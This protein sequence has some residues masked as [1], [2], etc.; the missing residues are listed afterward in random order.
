[1]V[2]TSKHHEGFCLWDS[3][4]T[5]Y[6]ITKTPFGRDLIKEY[7]AA[8]KAE[9][10]KV[11]YYYSVMD[12]H[13][14]DYTIDRPHPLFGRLHGKNLPKEEF[15]KKLAEMN[16]KRDMAKYRKYMFDQV[17]EL[18]TWYGKIDIIWFD[19]TPKGEYGKTW[20]D[21]D[22]VEL[23]KLARRLQPGILIDNRLDLLDTE[24]S[25]DF[26]TP[27]QYKVSETPK[28]NSVE[29]PWET[30]QTFSGSWGYYR[31]ESTWK[32][33]E[34]LIELLIHSVSFGGNLIMNVGPTARGEF[35]A[36]ACS[37]LEAFGKWMHSNSRSIYGCTAAPK[38]F[39]APA[40]TLL[41]YNP[42][43]KRLYVHLLAYPMGV[44][45]VDFAD[46][47]AYAQ[48]LHDGSELFV[49]EARKGH[50]QDGGARPG[51]IKLPMAK[52][53]VTIPVI[54]IFLKD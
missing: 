12:W 13:H 22:A 1:M 27:E 3:K 23:V 8:A 39:K 51:G 9:G 10:L 14:P 11:G 52:P 38:E 43:K 20:R 25:W 18:L 30:C 28:I 44:L 16:S 46:K 35:D 47:I 21:W 15:D 53:D 37:R 49:E 41:T 5:D 36:R 24:D 33:P 29:V 17:T 45:S 4:V 54:E 40:H 32:S 34:Q 26:A 7:V 6:K 42:E 48:F 31:D 19:Y 2:L 50:P